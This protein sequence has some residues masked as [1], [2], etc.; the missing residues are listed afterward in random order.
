MWNGTMFVDL[1]W[2]LNA[3]SPLSAS[4]ELLVLIGCAWNAKDR[5]VLTTT[6]STTKGAWDQEGGRGRLVPHEDIRDVGWVVLT[7][8]Q[9]N[10]FKCS[11]DQAKRAFFRAAS[12][13]FA[14][15]GR[16]TSEKVIV[17]SLKHCLRVN[18]RVCCWP[19]VMINLLTLW[20]TLVEFY[21]I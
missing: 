3:S 5:R 10:K 19:N 17:Q 21:F 12:S 11:I 1:D 14:K 13:V 20:Q 4:A 6:P 2:P 8:L 16:L 15:V 7:H 9:P 18:Y